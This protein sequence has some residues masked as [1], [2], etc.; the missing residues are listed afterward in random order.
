VAGSNKS[1][2]IFTVILSAGIWNNLPVC[3][4]LINSWSMKVMWKDGK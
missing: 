4:I 3:G 2:N 1:Y